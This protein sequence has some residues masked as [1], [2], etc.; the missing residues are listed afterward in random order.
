MYPAAACGTPGT[1]EYQSFLRSASWT[2][3]LRKRAPGILGIVAK[4]VFGDAGPEK[5]GR[6]FTTWEVTAELATMR[7][8]F[9]GEEDFK[10]LALGLCDRCGGR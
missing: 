3:L 4:Q 7:Q 6:F 5:A 1:T 8:T 9:E 2:R 10:V